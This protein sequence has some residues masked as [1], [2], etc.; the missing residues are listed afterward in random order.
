[1]RIAF[2]SDLETTLGASIAASRLASALAAEGHRVRRFHLQRQKTFYGHARDW[3]AQYVGLSA[4]AASIWYRTKRIAPARRLASY[5]VGAHLASALA[6]NP[7]D[8]LH[9]HNLH[10]SALDH[11][12]LGRLDPR[13]P[14]VWTFHD[15]WG[16]S[17]EA[18][19]LPGQGGSPER[20]WPDGRD[21]E[22]A[23]KV[24]REYF[25]SRQRL[26]LVAP[27]RMMARLAEENL[28]RPV[29]V[30][31]HGLDLSVFAPVDQ[32][33]ARVVFG[34]PEGTVCF[35]M[36]ADRFRNQYKGWAVLEKALASA[37]RSFVLLIAGEEDEA[38][39][40]ALGPGRVRV[41]GRIAQPQ[42]LGALL[43]AADALVMPSLVESF[44]QAAIEALACGTP[45]VSSNAGGLPE[46]VRHGET[47]AVVPAGDADALRSALD[48]VAKDRAR[49]ALMRPNCRAYAEREGGARLWAQRHLKIY[50]S[51]L[52]DSP[53]AAPDR[54]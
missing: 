37:E 51:L 19:L 47:G 10:T 17:P 36:V 25:D 20:I 31:P 27:S 1:V 13:L 48:G 40:F 33:A 2:V 30:V 5:V 22:A 39:E 15:C 35:A 49:W 16:F 6:E 34:V 44:G 45:V 18:W 26:A 32:S 41:L 24:R 53:A 50:Q 42:L 28:G 52:V 38:A 23:M 11:R 29:E 7:C 21:R 8:V 4:L 3:D 9:V 14:V 46:I 43:S 12:A 54:S